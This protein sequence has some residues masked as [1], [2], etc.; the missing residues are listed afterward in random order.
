MEVIHTIDDMKRFVKDR[1][2][3][4]KTI[5]FVPTMGY[6]HEGHVSLIDYAKEE[7][8]TVVVS[9]FVNPLQFNDPNDLDAY[10][11]SA[12][13]DT[14]MCTARGVDVLFMPPAR[15]M[16]PSDMGITMSLTKRMGVLC[17][18][19]RPGHFGGVL[20]VLTKLF[21]IIEPTK[22]YFGL[23][24]AQQVAVVDLLIEHLNFPTILRPIPTVR[25]PDGLAKSSRNVNLSERER[26]DA[27]LIYRALTEAKAMMEQGE[28]DQETILSHVQSVI[29]QSRHA[30][31]DYIELLSYPQLEALPILKGQVILAC[32]VKFERARL[33]DNVLVDL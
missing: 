25:E 10:P 29:N 28:R 21:H 7:T 5:G 6:L 33:I 1:Q 11:K 22:V 20:T 23:K 32:A 24:D 3:A 2:A 16:Y 26:Q 18:R 13:R 14:D 27:P 31:I 9:V 15:E 12:Q 8:D 17:D 4:Q 19:T 30:E